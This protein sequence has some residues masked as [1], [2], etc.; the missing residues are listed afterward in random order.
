[1]TSESNLVKCAEYG[2]LISDSNK[3]SINL[4]GFQP[5]LTLDSL[6][7][8]KSIKHNNTLKNNFYNNN[9]NNNN[10]RYS[11]KSQNRDLLGQAERGKIGTHTSSECSSNSSVEA[12][13][14]SNVGLI[15]HEK[16][17]R[18]QINTVFSSNQS[19]ERNKVSRLNSLDRDSLENMPDINTINQDVCEFYFFFF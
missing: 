17:D 8:S 10:I 1:L 7:T 19:D 14:E 4:Q 16:K 12:S 18:R 6:S 9:I 3:Q 15:S 5:I 11:S 13:V 2:G